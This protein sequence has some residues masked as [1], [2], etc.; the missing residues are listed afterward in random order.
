[1]NW[2]TPPTE[3]PRLQYKVPDTDSVDFLF[4]LYSDWEVSKHLLR[5][6]YPF[7]HAEAERM[8][9]GILADYEAGEAL[10][11]IVK[12]RHDDVD[13]GLV[14]L[15]MKGTLGYSVIRSQWNHGYA[16]EAAGTMMEY[17]FNEIGFT[18]IEAGSVEDNRASIR[19][20]EKLG[21]TVHKQSVVEN[22]LHSEERFVRRFRVSNPSAT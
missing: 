13:V 15:K 16:T 17:A 2:P 6:V 10:T 21:F 5:V 9:A 11:M 12:R 3:S 8:L 19:V 14:A 22:S 7:T 20:L 18:T 1:M 4:R